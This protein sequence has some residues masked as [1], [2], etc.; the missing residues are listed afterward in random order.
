VSDNRPI[1]LEFLRQHGHTYTWLKPG[2]NGVRLPHVNDPDIIIVDW[3]EADEGNSKY[4]LLRRLHQSFR[5][6]HVIN[7]TPD[8]VPRAVSS[9]EIGT[10]LS[11]STSTDLVILLK[12]IDTLLGIGSVAD[13]TSAA[14]PEPVLD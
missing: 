13:F 2:D 5:R 10:S 11:F 3:S 1:W 9:H 4:N 6:A 7:L 8:V 12:A 14:P